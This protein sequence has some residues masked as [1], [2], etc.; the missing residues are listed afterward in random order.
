M[1]D[2]KVLLVQKISK[3]IINVCDVTGV[4]HGV[5]WK[6]ERIFIVLSDE[7][8]FWFDTSHGRSL[9]WKRPGERLCPH[10]YGLDILDL[11]L[12]LRYG[13]K[14]FITTEAFSSLYHTASLQMYISI[15]WLRLLFFYSWS[16]F[17]RVFS[18]FSN[19]ARMGHH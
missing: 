3:V 8:R 14:I 12:E 5:R 15:W 7:S 4:K 11:L 16:A 10:I 13:E 1:V 2:L 18:S 17:K 6:T 19:L 9:V